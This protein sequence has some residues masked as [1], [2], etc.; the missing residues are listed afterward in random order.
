[1]LRRVAEGE[2]AQD[3][4]LRQEE[5]CEVCSTQVFEVFPLRVQLWLGLLNL[6]GTHVVAMGVDIQKREREEVRC[7]VI[8]SLQI[9]FFFIAI[10]LVPVNTFQERAWQF[11]LHL[12]ISPGLVINQKSTGLLRQSGGGK[13]AFLKSALFIEKRAYLWISKSQLNS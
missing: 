7:C 3:P 11:S 12:S 5:A 4:F 1:M 13:Q 8:S 9:F 2:F 6:E 10:V